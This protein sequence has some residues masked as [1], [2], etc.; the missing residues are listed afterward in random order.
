[1]E[2]RQKRA[3][4]IVKN[5]PLYSSPTRIN[6]PCF[7]KM[8]LSHC[9]L[10]FLPLACCPILSCLSKS[11]LLFMTTLR[12][13]YAGSGLYFQSV[14][15]CSFFG[16]C[17]TR[18][19]TWRCKLFCGWILTCCLFYKLLESKC[20]ILP[21]IL[22]ALHIFGQRGTQTFINEWKEKRECRYG[23]ER[24]E[25]RGARSQKWERDL[26]ERGERDIT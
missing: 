18:G 7:P 20:P 11:F 25:R 22:N 1:M 4:I 13:C 9:C 14:I 10:C 16:L 24:K 8:F 26:K 23:E 15:M 2:R 12:H 5:P 6:T 17:K 21:G 19:F 3:A